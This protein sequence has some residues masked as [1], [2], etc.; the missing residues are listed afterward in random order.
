MAKETLHIK[1]QDLKEVK[2]GKK[3]GEKEIIMDIKIDQKAVTH[4]IINNF[5]QKYVSI[6]EAV[7]TA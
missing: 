1:K 3:D 2:I 5:F 4:V 7:L 6:F